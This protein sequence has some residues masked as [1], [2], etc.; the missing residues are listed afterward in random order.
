M[1]AKANLDQDI[2]DI[3][4]IGSECL[5]TFQRYQQHVMQLGRETDQLRAGMNNIG[6]SVRELKNML[7]ANDID[8]QDF[9][10]SQ[11]I[12]AGRQAL[13]SK[14]NV[15]QQNAFVIN[16][17]RTELNELRCGMTVFKRLLTTYGF[18]F[19]NLSDP[20]IMMESSR[21]L[22]GKLSLLVGT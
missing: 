16:D 13:E 22:E 18:D 4:N 17:L 5:A 21:F 8:T 9:S 20:E 10:E 3:L 12:N 15:I 14:M 19:S 2:V 11:I 7:E 6:T 1:D